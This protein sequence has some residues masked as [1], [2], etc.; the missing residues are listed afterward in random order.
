MCVCVIPELDE[1]KLCTFKFDGKR[2]EFR[3][4]KSATSRCP[5]PQQFD[6][7]SSCPHPSVIWYARI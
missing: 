7:S 5:W 4:V 3:Q 6:V 1:G 2:P